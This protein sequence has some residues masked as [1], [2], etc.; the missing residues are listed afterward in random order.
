MGWQRKIL[1]GNTASKGTGY[2]NG[3]FGLFV[4]G[5][6][7][8]RVSDLLVMFPVWADLSLA[9]GSVTSGHSRALN[10]KLR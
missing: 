10:V 1:K 5:M 4:P 2:Q 9:Q 3:L 7:E 6:E 8:I